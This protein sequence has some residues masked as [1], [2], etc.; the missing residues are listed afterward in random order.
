MQLHDV[1]SLGIYFLLAY[2]MISP[3]NPSMLLIVLKA[4][5]S[6]EER[7][8]LPCLIDSSQ[9][10]VWDAHIVQQTSHNLT[11]ILTGASGEGPGSAVVSRSTSGDGK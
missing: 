4:H 6:T 8:I 10:C 5:P 1:V 9:H 11:W 7:T 3:L 2:V